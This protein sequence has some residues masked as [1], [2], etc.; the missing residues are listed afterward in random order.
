MKINSLTTFTAI[1]ISAFFVCSAQAQIGFANGGFEIAGSGASAA[2]SWLNAA[3]GYTRSTDAF[4]GM[5]SMQLSSPQVNASVAL[6]NSVGDGGQPPLTEGDELVLSFQAK[7]FAGTTGNVLF[8]LAFLAE[9]GAI[10]YTSGLQF[11]Q[12]SINPTTW[13]EITF[14]ADAVPVGA[15]FCFH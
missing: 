3:E 7:G 11:F 9:D 2:E 8:S 4:E 15:G 6:Q 5:F 1:A 14:A 12:D 10:L 13:T